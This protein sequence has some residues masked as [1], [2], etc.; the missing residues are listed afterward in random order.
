[1]LKRG[2]TILIN[3]PGQSPQNQQPANSDENVL[4]EQ[5]L[6]ISGGKALEGQ[7]NVQGAKN[8]VL[9]ILAAAILVDGEVL[10]HNCPDLSDSYG[11]CRILTHLGCKCKRN[12][13]DIFVN[14]KDVIENEIPDGLM[15]PMRSSIVFM[16]SMIGRNNACRL[17]MPGGCELGSRPID[18]HVRA[19][20][21]MGANIHNVGGMLNCD[22]PNGLKGANII[23]RFASV[24]ATENI[25]LAAVLAD[26]VTTIN[27]AAREPEIIDLADFLVA[28]G[29]KITGAGSSEIV[30]HGVERLHG[31]EF[32]IMADR[33]AAATYL[34]AA[35][36]TRGTV[37][38]KDAKAKDLGVIIDVLQQM[39]CKVYTF[40]GG[41]GLN[42]MNRK[43][44]GVPGEIRT[45]PFPAFPTDAQPM[46]LALAATVEGTTLFYET[47]FENRYQHVPQ[48]RRL[49]AN[50]RV[51]DRTAVIEGVPKLTGADLSAADLRGAAALVTAALAAHGKSTLSNLNHLDRGYEHFAENLRSIGADIYRK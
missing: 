2:V 31:A 41:V 51:L 11:A 27:N 19:L 38:L 25:I 48:L 24:G 29:A 46:L 17:S 40:D 8:S 44:V 9:P 12:G 4:R 23:L 39:N 7:L 15:R 35:A 16:G 34:C 28:C 36:S 32:T 1:M 20:E 37:V 6:Y 14:A 49:G 33:I 30:I 22:A 13:S 47:V 3:K 21:A 45:G 10:L 50:I 18:L 43:L 26:G 5:R 42:A